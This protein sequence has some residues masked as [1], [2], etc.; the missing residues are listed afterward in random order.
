MASSH[1]SV[2]PELRP[3]PDLRE[4]YAAS[5]PGRRRSPGRR[6]SP[7]RRPRSRL[8]IHA[9][10]SPRHRSRSPG[11]A[12]WRSHTHPP[13]GGP[14]G[15]E[16][17]PAPPT[18]SVGD[19]A[20]RSFCQI[21]PALGVDCPDYTDFDNTF[22]QWL[23]AES[24]LPP[25]SEDFQRS[26]IAALRAAGLALP[27]V[28]AS[29][30]VPDDILIDGRSATPSEL[31]YSRAVALVAR[32]RHGGPPQ[33]FPPA[34]PPPLDLR[35][36]A[37]A[38]RPRRRHPDRDPSDDSRDRD[39]FD[40]HTVL[41]RLPPPN[42]NVIDVRRFAASARLRKLSREALRGRS[43]PNGRWISH[44]PLSQ[45]LPEWLGEGLDR[46]AR[47]ALEKSRASIDT[48]PR[49]LNSVLSFWLSHL[50]VGFGT[51][52]AIIE[53]IAILGQIA[54]ERSVRAAIYYEHLFLDYIRL[55]AKHGDPTP[56]EDDLARRVPSIWQKLCLESTSPG[57]GLRPPP[58]P[59]TASGSR[60]SGS[61]KPKISLR[62]NSEKRMVCL[63]H[64]PANGKSCTLPSCSKRH[65]DTSMPSNRTFFDRVTRMAAQ[66]STKPKSAPSRPALPPA[67]AAR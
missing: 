56:L 43:T 21:A 36:L 46:D 37:R 65:L 24:S 1:G 44:A 48:F 39:G 38:I 34:P 32:A 59:G 19:L 49:L 18:P 64:D 57:L 27:S 8:R 17:A 42:N 15:P 26:I 4:A 53:H 54:E 25:A 60:P 29:A 62:P 63:L 40:L 55:R 31:T 41:A 16:P 14:L 20:W 23:C 35:D 61:A 28:L 11:K 6:P 47:K 50:A 66:A 30:S 9:S 13:L 33:P 7:T 10:L 12:V 2:L 67:P 52:P 58:A 5:S 3:P 51:L 45:W 22:V